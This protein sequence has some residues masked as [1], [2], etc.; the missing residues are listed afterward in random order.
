MVQ[1][2]FQEALEQVLSIELEARNV[3]EQAREQARAVR[4]RGS[5]EAE[6]KADLLLEDARAEAER[7]VAAAQAEAE[8]E[9]QRRLAETTRELEVRE[10]TALGRMDAAVRFVVDRLLGESTRVSPLDA[11][12]TPRGEGDRSRAA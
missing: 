2:Q 11:V 6:A 10:R 4:A 8:Q 5:R 3:L 1:Q 7:M 12:P 9:R